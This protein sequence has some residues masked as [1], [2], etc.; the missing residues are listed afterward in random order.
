[1]PLVVSLGF[2]SGHAPCNDE[3]IR[4]CCSN[5]KKYKLEQF[6]LFWTGKVTSIG[7]SL[8]LYASC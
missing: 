3:L 4:Q 5:I 2:F 6:F 7:L 8:S 1:M